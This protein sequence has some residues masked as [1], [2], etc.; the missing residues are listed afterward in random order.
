MG[1]FDWIKGSSKN[2][3]IE[4]YENEKKRKYGY[5]NCNWLSQTLKIIDRELNLLYFSIFRK[6]KCSLN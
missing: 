4:K 5:F 2:S 1:I 6:H 3:D